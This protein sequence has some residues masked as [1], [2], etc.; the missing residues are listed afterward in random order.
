MSKRTVGGSEADA[1][2]YTK[3][4]LL[5]LTLETER[6]EAY[7]KAAE[8][9][10]MS[11]WTRYCFN[12]LRARFFHNGIS[13]I[14]F[15]PGVARIAYSELDMDTDWEDA[16]AL[17]QLDMIVQT[18]SDS[19][20][21]EYNRH[22]NNSTYKGLA[23]I[24]GTVLQSNLSHLKHELL[25]RSYGERRYDIVHLDSFQ[26]AKQYY[27]STVLHTDS[28]ILQNG[29][30]WCHLNSEHMF[31]TY[32]RNHSTKLY[33]A[34]LPGY[35]NI[36]EDDP[37]FGESMLGIDI[38]M[39]GEL[40]HVNNRWNHAHDTIDVRKGDNKYSP[41]ELSDLLGGP[42]FEL[43]KPFSEEDLEVYGYTKK[44]FH[45]IRAQCVHGTFTDPR[46]GHV[47]TTV[48]LGRQT[49]ICENIC[50]EGEQLPSPNLN[51]MYSK[52]GKHPDFGVF[53]S[54]RGALAAVPPGCRL[55]SRAD[56]EWLG[57][58]IRL[59]SQ[60]SID[61]YFDN[62]EI[63]ILNTP[64]KKNS[65]MNLYRLKT[66]GFDNPITGACIGGWF[67]KQSDKYKK[68]LYWT[69]DFDEVFEIH[70]DDDGIDDNNL[71]GDPETLLNYMNQHEVLNYMN[72]HEVSVNKGVEVEIDDDGMHF[73]HTEPFIKL[74]IKCILCE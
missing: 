56:W 62:M 70:D 67:T 26:T 57:N 2:R 29:S 52:N 60:G 19:H 55:P 30:G 64:K 23:E 16:Q 27:E 6:I 34:M 54:R 1:Y 24:Y 68:L 3:K 21:A 25:S 47:Y 10:C 15:M 31:N 36:T 41:E 50:Y 63:A 4:V 22:L 61:T 33:I 35:E 45:Q 48:K 17:Q 58:Y 37:L 73:R 72:Q 53:Y 71:T 32:S 18:I 7:V 65:N 59:F 40:I 9:N 43:C 13:D 66:L 28:T 51:T 42:Y 8:L 5:G 38:G 74:P 14:R 46:D 12:E 11:S 20:S 39:N 69:R 49:W 44:T